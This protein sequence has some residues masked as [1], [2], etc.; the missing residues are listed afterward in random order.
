M[1]E[2]NV[3]CVERDTAIGIAARRTVFEV[4]LDGHAQRRKLA[5][6]LMVAACVEAHL[7]KVIAVAATDDAIVEY[8]S[9]AAGHFPLM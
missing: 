2:G 4:S 8:G 6:Y 7:Q 5:T 3:A 9:L 1:L